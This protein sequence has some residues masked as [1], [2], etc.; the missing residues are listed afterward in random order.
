MFSM[1]F[2]I[3]FEEQQFVRARLQ[4]LHSMPILAALARRI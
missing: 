2:G 3:E 1:K 4:N